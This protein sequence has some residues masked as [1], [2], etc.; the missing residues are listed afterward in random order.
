MTNTM[1]GTV[2]KDT[3]MSKTN[4]GGWKNDN[5]RI[6]YEKLNS[7]KV[8]YPDTM[9]HTFHRAP[10]IQPWYRNLGNLGGPVNNL[11]FTPEDRVGPTLGYH[12][13]D[14]Y[15]YNIDSLHFYNTRR[16]YS[17]FSYLLGS[18][19]EQTASLS[20][21]QNIRPNWN[22]F[23]EY[24]KTNSRGF[25]NSQRSNNDN[26]CV[27][28]NYKS[29]D[30][31]Y[32]LYV[33]AVYNKEQTDENGGVVKEQQMDF[34]STQY[35]DRRVLH[36]AYM[37][38]TYSPQLTR[39]PVMNTL[40]DFTFLLQHSYQWGRT[41]TTYNADST[42]Y[43]A[44]LVPRFSISHKLALSTE[45]H[46]YKDLAPDSLRYVSLF[47]RQFTNGGVY[48]PGIDSVLTRQKWFWVDNQFLLNGYIG[49]EGKQMAFR[50][51]FGT[52]Y[53]RF[54]SDPVSVL[55]PDTVVRY[56]IGKDRADMV[57]NYLAGE[58]KKE[59]LQPGEWEYGANTKFFITGP[60]AGSFMLNALIGKQLKNNLGSFAAGFSQRLNTPPYSYTTYANIYTKIT[61]DMDKESVTTLFA[62]LESPRLRLSAGYRNHVINNFIFVSEQGMPDQ[63]SGTFSIS[64]VW[65][66]KVFKAGFFYLDNELVLQQV[67]GNAPVNVPPVMG[68]HQL[69]YERRLF[70]NRLVLAA[71]IEGRYNT[72]YKPASYNAL[73]NK[74]SYQ[75]TKTVSNTP[76]VA[77]FLSFR[78]KKF[79][80]FIMGDNLQEI[81][82]RNAFIYTGSPVLN[83][84]NKGVNYIPVYA[85]P[86]ALIRF[87]FTWVLAN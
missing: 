37:D 70:K 50:A 35:G 74:F 48:K 28:S 62:T 34:D 47:E 19:L 79:R 18:K 26:A 54:M 9:L 38:N 66:R 41:D 45:K 21:T 80:A 3:S 5:P 31:R 61:L 65:V 24:R 64:Q 11:L 63:Y 25:F 84:E 33:G 87:G 49:K 14:V 15:R 77:L 73:L 68:R 82:S 55:I 22:V 23:V 59:A 58:I 1:P 40:R 4:N 69:S 83:Y 29:P 16:P 81:F 10:F 13:Y 32:L 86:D 76:E 85:A 27:T 71:G 43:T 44:V 12:V 17:S 57:N 56:G 67:P 52:R 6:E 72:A 42:Q 60:Q 53:D 2:A 30:K 39:S 8:Y 36:T 20:H 78:V 75:D 46:T 7:A 51:G